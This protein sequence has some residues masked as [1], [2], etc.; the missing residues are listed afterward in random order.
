MSI[1]RLF[2]LCICF[3][4]QES[5]A[6]HYGNIHIVQNNNYKKQK[7]GEKPYLESPLFPHIKQRTVALSQQS[8]KGY[9]VI[10][11][12]SK[13]PCVTHYLLNGKPIAQLLQI[14][15]E[16]RF[17]SCNQQIYDFVVQNPLCLGSLA[18]E[19]RGK[20]TFQKPIN[21]YSAYVTCKAVDFFETFFS[22]TG[23]LIKA[24]HC[25]NYSDVV[26]SEIVFDG[27]SF[28][29]V[30]RSALLVYQSALFSSK[31]RLVNDGKMLCKK[32]AVIDTDVCENFGMMNMHNMSLNS[33]KIFNQGTID[34]DDSFRCSCESFDHHGMFVVHN[35]SEICS[36]YLHRYI[37]C[38]R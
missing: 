5:C 19:I 11:E 29:N 35:G 4:V 23:L 22:K 15:D 25:T 28:I 30:S 3:I 9:S 16:M 8:Y 27:N 32:D 21:T 7:K 18:V 33:N 34:I 17:K 10:F 13:K 14:D 24:D 38:C 26:C 37:I 2:F 6:M 31:Q 20:C 12:Q 36:R 1:F